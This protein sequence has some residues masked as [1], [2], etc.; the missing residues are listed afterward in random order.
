M[1]NSI[2]GYF[3]R[4]PTRVSVKAVHGV[5]LDTWHSKQIQD[6]NAVVR[7]P[8]TGSCMANQYMPS[9]VAT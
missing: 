8:M 5:S 1:S 3:L 7:F 9:G 4:S 2:L 6:D